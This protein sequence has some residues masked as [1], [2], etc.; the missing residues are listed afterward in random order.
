MTSVDSISPE[1]KAKAEDLKNQANV[2]FKGRAC[3]LYLVYLGTL[4]KQTEHLF[5]FVY[6]E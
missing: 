6:L 4:Y 5:C 1:N 3:M 2:F